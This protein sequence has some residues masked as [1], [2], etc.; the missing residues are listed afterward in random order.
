MIKALPKG[1]A[2]SLC[3]IQGLGV[4]GGFFGFVAVFLPSADAYGFTVNTECSLSSSTALATIH[5]NL[6]VQDQHSIFSQV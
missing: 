4:A 6:T 2:F 5:T 3:A 1:G